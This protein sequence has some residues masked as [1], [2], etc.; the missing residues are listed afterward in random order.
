[1]KPKFKVGE[2]C[3]RRTPQRLSFVKILSAHV[4]C[5]KV[6]YSVSPNLAFVDEANLIEMGNL[7]TYY[8]DVVKRLL[9]NKEVK[10]SEFCL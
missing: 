10:C 7:E 6:Y 1:M 4:F 3:Y 2:Y 5:G 9:A 8:L